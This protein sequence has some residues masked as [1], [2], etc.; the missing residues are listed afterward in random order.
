M[1][2]A[3]GLGYLRVEDSVDVVL[4]ALQQLRSQV[5]DL[6]FQLFD[7]LIFLRYW[8]SIHYL[9]QSLHHLLNA[10]PLEIIALAQDDLSNPR[11]PFRVDLVGLPLQLVLISLLFQI[12]L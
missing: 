5:S 10:F 11:E 4:R 12:D 6:P 1:L 2:Q 7:I 9:C 8:P 3:I